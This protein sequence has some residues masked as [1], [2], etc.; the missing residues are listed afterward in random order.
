MVFY[1]VY[2]KFAVLS[3]KQPILIK[4]RNK[5]FFVIFITSSKGPPYFLRKAIK[6]GTR[7]YI[8]FGYKLLSRAI[9]T[10]KIYRYRFSLTIELVFS[11]IMTKVVCQR[12]YPG[13]NS[14]NTTT[15]ICGYIEIF[16]FFLKTEFT[17]NELLAWPA[18]NSANV[19][20][21][22]RG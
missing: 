10:Q 20:T 15:K 19:V 13:A 7:L 2:P 22:T 11:L 9:L 18:R 17:S 12:W 6:V 8:Q 21:V 1:I 3:Q 4:F 5:I 16:L 14:L